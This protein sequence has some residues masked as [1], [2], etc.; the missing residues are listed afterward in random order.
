MAVSKKG[1]RT[2]IY[3][4]KTYIWYVWSDEESEGRICLFIISEDKKLILSYPLNSASSF[5]I[6]QGTKFQGKR[7]SG[8][9]EM[10][11]VPFKIPDVITP[12]AV[13]KLIKWAE[14]GI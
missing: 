11:E 8:K 2:I 9:W 3:N 1:R 5:V 14:E 4:G 12:K 10:V 13:F 6:S 7:T